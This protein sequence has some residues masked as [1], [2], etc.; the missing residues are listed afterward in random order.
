[1]TLL[2][3]ISSFVAEIKLYALQIQHYYANSPTFPGGLYGRTIAKYGMGYFHATLVSLQPHDT[4]LQRDSIVVRTHLEY[5][6]CYKE[7]V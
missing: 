1:M 3:Q 4:V 6:L 5:S 7:T 2:L